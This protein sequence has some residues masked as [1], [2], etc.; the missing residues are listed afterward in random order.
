V[1][2]IEAAVGGSA[3]D[4]LRTQ[5]GLIEEV[6][7]KLKANPADLP[8]RIDKLLQNLKEK[9]TELDR[10]Q[11][12]L[13][14]QMREE[15]LRG[16]EIVEGLEVI[17]G[18]VLFM[19]PRELRSLSDLL[20]D[21]IGSGVIVLAASLDDRVHWVVGTSSQAMG[22]HAGKLVNEIAQI[23]EGKGGGRPDLAEGSGRDAGK[24]DQAL[25]AVPHLIRRLVSK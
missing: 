12:H 24:I 7:S 9:E 2:R 25:A 19:G 16:K 6:A 20:K 14:L 4:H 10:L 18:K 21:R 11:H 17:T 22:L 23:T 5:E 3:W 13:M 1:R 8:G 15:L